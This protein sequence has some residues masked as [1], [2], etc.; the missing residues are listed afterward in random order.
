[1]INF[2]EELLKYQPVLELDNIE[3][4]LHSGEMQDL[5]D[6]LQHISREKGNKDQINNDKSNHG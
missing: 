6:I 4:A 1:M 3:D 2:K 5:L